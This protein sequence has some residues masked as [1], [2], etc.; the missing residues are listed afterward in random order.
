MFID[1]TID[2]VY[3]IKIITTFNDNLIMIIKL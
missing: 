2:K 1:S 3:H